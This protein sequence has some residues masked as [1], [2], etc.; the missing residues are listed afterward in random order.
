MPRM[1]KLKNTKYGPVAI[2]KEK[3]LL[4]D[5]SSIHQCNEFLRSLNTG[6][7][8]KFEGFKQYISLLQTIAFKLNIPY[9]VE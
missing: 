6:L 9:L 5:P 8:I 7:E 1:I 3:Y 4:T 2:I